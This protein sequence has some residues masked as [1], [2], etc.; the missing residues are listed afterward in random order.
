HGRLCGLVGEGR[1]VAQAPSVPGVS[2][3]TSASY[4]ALATD[5]AALRAGDLPGGALITE[6]WVHGQP[7]ACPD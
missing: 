4:R 3:G 1:I 2:F 5:T 6:I 7:T